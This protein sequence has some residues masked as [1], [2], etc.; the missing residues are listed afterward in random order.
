MPS[1]EKFWFW[2]RK[3][4]IEERVVVA[5]AVPAAIAALVWLLVPT[6]GHSSTSVSTGALGGNSGQAQA[7]GLPSSSGGTASGGAGGSGLAGGAGSSSDGANGSAASPGAPSA[8]GASGSSTG[9]G[10][11]A[12][13]GSGPGAS[14]TRCTSP[15]GSAPGVTAKQIKIAV[16]ITNIAGAAGNETFG[17]VSPAQAQAYVQDIVD[18]INASGGVA[19]RQLVPLYYQSNPIDQSNMESTCLQITQAGVFAEI[20]QGGESVLPGPTC[21]AQHGIPY[22]DSANLLAQ[23]TISQYY[24]YLFVPFA[25]FDTTDHN[26]VFALRD[27]GFFS[28]ANGFSKLGF[29]YLDCYPTVIS[30]FMGWLH[31]AGLTDS[32]IVPYDLGCPADSFASPGDEEQAVLKFQQAGVTNV[33]TEY[34]AGSFSNFTTIAEQQGFKPK[35]GVPDEAIIDISYGSQHPNYNNIAGAIAITDSRFGEEHTPSLTPTPATAKCNSY[36]TSR[37]QPTLYQMGVLTG[38]N[39]GVMCDELWMFKAAVEHAPV[40]SPTALAAGLQA[41]R[42]VDFSYPLSPND[43]SGNRVT[44][45]GEFWRPVEFMTSC[46]CWQVID[47]TFHPSYS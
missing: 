44:Y 32:Q 29:V 38:A 1:F 41:A 34:M 35:Y 6:G 45:G 33:T 21:F 27:R 30:E 17:G 10:S 18:G 16:T 22:F 36:F 31:Q 37:G 2:A 5:L 28:R 9:P 13:G 43:F 8:G 25:T 39:M 42:S 19:C 14:G 24:P 15:P 12:A 47:P 26:A 7:P 40:L 23:S 3:A 20:D 11:S 4:P 46:T